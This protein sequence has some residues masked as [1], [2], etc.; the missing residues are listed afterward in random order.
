MRNQDVFP[1]SSPMALWLGI[2]ALTLFVPLSGAAPPL[3]D[4]PPSATP[5]EYLSTPVD[6]S[7]TPSDLP[8]ATVTSTTEP[9]EAPTPAA[10]APASH[11]GEPYASAPQCEDHDS[12]TYHG[13]WDSARGCH[14]DHHHGDDPHTVDDVFGTD[15]Y[16]WAGGSI[17]YPWQ[18]VNPQTGCLENDCKHTGYVWLVR[19]DQRCYSAFTNGCVVAFRALV[20]AMA[21][22][23]DTSVRY[24]S[25]WL[26]AKVC[27]EDAPQV[28][29]IF[30]SGGWQD[31]G[32]LLIDRR[33]VID[34]PNNFNRF[35][36]HFLQA[37]N[38]RFGTWYSMSPG[39][40]EK[41]GGLWGV[42]VEL[43]DMWG[44]LDPADPHRM[45]F[46]C[47]DPDTNCSWN[48]SRY[49]P[50]VIGVQFPPRFRSIVDPDRNNIAIY[51]GFADRWGVPAAGCTTVSR[52]CIPLVIENVP[53]RYQYQ[54]R[55]DYRE[56]DVLFD[57]E[58]SGWIQ[59]PD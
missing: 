7:A 51:D 30:R 31:T 46:F 49:Q 40:E 35:K 42:T 57:G 25:A 50:H 9:T 56:Y 33:R 23:H 29:G 32:D 58:T 14:Y 16:D 45:Q 34:Y 26:E 12:R 13:L 41:R 53:I 6:P 48:G 2:A 3:Q 10:A 52:D 38:A 37:G 47:D 11:P 27:R 44:P 22:S 5:T 28:C 21:S 4:D 15:Y 39:G 54:G 55:F 20:H 59:F 1:R 43:G 18:T 17:S 8:T 19:R 36:L 24:H